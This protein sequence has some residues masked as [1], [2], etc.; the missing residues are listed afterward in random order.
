MIELLHPAQSP[1]LNLM[2][3]LWSYL[4]RKVRAANIKAIEG[5]KRRLTMEWE[6]LPWSYVRTSVKSMPSRLAQCVELEDGR[7]WY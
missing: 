4:D 1:D 5:L 7:T 6:K 3:D 2:E